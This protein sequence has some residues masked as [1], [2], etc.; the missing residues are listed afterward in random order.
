MTWKSLFHD[1]EMITSGAYAKIFLAALN[2]KAV[3]KK[4]Y[5]VR[6]IVINPSYL[7]VGTFTCLC[8]SLQK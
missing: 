6:L 1:E 3:V 2:I 7:E 8:T 4:I 5:H